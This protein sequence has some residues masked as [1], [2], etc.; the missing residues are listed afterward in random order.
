M[1]FV[2]AGGNLDVPPGASYGPNASRPRTWR[3][4][5]PRQAY[6]G[7]SHKHASLAQST[8]HFA[9]VWRILG[10]AAIEW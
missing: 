10:E 9:F 8:L 6:W 1:P 5:R 3:E 2:P 7:S 4:G